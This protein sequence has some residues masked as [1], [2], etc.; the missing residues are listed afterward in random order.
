[1][2]YLRSDPLPSNTV[3]RERARVLANT[4]PFPPA[5]IETVLRRSTSEF[6]AKMVL[7]YAVAHGLTPEGAIDALRGANG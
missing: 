7:A 1:M 2:V 6:G 3:L 4:Y 5:E